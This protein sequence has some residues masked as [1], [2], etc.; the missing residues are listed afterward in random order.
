MKRAIASV[1]ENQYVHYY[2]YLS[3]PTMEKTCIPRCVLRHMPLLLLDEY[4]QTKHIG[5]HPCMWEDTN[6]LSLIAAAA[7][8]PVLAGGF[9]A[10]VSSDAAALMCSQGQ[11]KKRH[12]S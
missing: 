7:P 8:V 3:M 4:G 1:I 9:S 11:K 2:D 6:A 12:F 5:H 10:M